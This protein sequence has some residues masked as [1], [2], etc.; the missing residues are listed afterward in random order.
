MVLVL[1]APVFTA[2]SEAS[3]AHYSEA[4]ADTCLGCHNS[5]AMRV[6]FRTPHGQTADP[7]SPMA[8]LQC[9]ACHGPG[10]DH[11]DRRFVGGTHPAV[12]AFG[13]NAMSTV[14]EQN[15]PCVACH[16]PDVGLGWHGSPH[17]AND[18]ACVACHSVHS[19]RDPV[20]LQ[21][22]QAEVCFDCHRAQRSASLKPSTHPIRFNHMTCTDCHDPHGSVA[23]GLLVRNTTNELCTDCHSEFRGPMLFDH[24]PVS[25]DCTLCH[26]PHGSVH[27]A[28]LTRRAPLLCQSCHSPRGHPSLSFTEQSLPGGNPSAMVLSGSCLNCHTRIHG[29]NHPSGFGLMR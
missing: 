1:V 21:T 23:D 12:V 9:E 3:S 7:D 28:L 20:S 2:A 29:S 10:G 16:E 14:E 25:E 26:D 11:S 5:E 17:E 6:I 4:G 13:R 27:E 18:T 22:E 24:A 8:S 19:A 15:A